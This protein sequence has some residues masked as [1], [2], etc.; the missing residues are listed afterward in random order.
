MSTVLGLDV[1]TAIVGCCVLRDDACFSSSDVKLSIDSLSVVDLRKID[2]VFEK[3]DE[4]KRHL[5]EI[6]KTVDVDR[7]V[8]EAALMGFRPG[9]SNAQTITTLVKFNGMVS[10]VS[11]DV[12]SIRPSYVSSTHARKVCGI[13]VVKTS[14]G[15]PQKLQVFDFLSKNDLSHIVWPK[16]RK[17][18]KV[19]DWSYD[20]ADAFVVARSSL[21]QTNE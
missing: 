9:M 2:S 19:V 14:V 16:K 15:G 21:L 11:R 5:Q 8:I 7:I 18:E 17:S 3:A 13:K 4:V 6:K 20:A 10:L 12:F 1:S